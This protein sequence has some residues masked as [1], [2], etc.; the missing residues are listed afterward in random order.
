MRAFVF[1]AVV[2]R[3]LEFP[4]WG[5]YLP[6]L[7]AL[8]KTGSGGQKRMPHNVGLC[9]M[10]GKGGRGAGREPCFYKLVAAV[11]GLKI[12]SKFVETG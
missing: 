5:R 12:F 3:I 10:D 8:H 9:G 1:C 2:E 6:C 11:S 4:I 7:R